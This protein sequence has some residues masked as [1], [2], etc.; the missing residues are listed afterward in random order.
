VNQTQVSTVLVW[1]NLSDVRTYMYVEQISIK[2]EE[3]CIVVV[4]LH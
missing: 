4:E 1:C 2:L 3:K